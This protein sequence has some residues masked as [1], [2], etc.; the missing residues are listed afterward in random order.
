MICKLSTKTHISVT[1]DNKKKNNIVFLNA[2]IPSSGLKR[3]FTINVKHTGK[4]EKSSMEVI[5]LLR[6]CQLS[7]TNTCI[8]FTCIKKNDNFS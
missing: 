2:M 7:K 3:L 5:D 4:F 6:G 1:E 8:I